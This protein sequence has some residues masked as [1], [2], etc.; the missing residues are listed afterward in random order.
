MRLA[1]N[2]YVNTECY[3]W[4]A[5]WPAITSLVLMQTSLALLLPQ[6][7]PLVSMTLTPA[8][9]LHRYVL[10]L[11][12]LKWLVVQCFPCVWTACGSTWCRLCLMLSP[13][14]NM[15]RIICF[16]GQGLQGAWP[17]ALNNI[18]TYS[19]REYHSAHAWYQEWYGKKQSSHFWWKRTPESTEPK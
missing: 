9:T 10:G 4:S 13:A 11:F 16:P 17:P 7:T 6:A 2:Y 12:S 3:L 15:W 19:K 1:W 8:P 18:M 5:L 14:V